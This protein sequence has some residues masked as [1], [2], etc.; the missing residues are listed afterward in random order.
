MKRSVT[1]HDG[2]YSHDIVPPSLFIAPTESRVGVKGDFHGREWPAEVLSA[3]DEY[4]TRL[5]YMRTTEWT[6]A[7]REASAELEE[8][9]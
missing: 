9:R 5:G 6:M 7:D 1:V 2:A 3:A 4:L 8:T